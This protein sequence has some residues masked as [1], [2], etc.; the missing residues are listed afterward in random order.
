MA[1]LNRMS[2]AGELSEQVG[3]GRARRGQGSGACSP[4][5]AVPRRRCYG[6]VQPPCRR[7]TRVQVAP[8]VW[9]SKQQLDGAWAVVCVHQG[10]LHACR[11][12]ASARETSRDG[13][14]PAGERAK[15]CAALAWICGAPGLQLQP[16]H[17]P[18]ARHICPP[19]PPSPPMQPQLARGLRRWP[20]PSSHRSPAPP[21]MVV[22]VSSGR[23]TR[24]ARL[25]PS[26]WCTRRAVTSLQ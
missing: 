18:H 10:D 9:Q 6:L 11:V 4:P 22:G 16:A 21:W 26:R 12:G 25:T 1:G 5:P 7:R 13:S 19:H 23:G 2:P 8:A 14:A 15:V 24:N 3:S 20:G 17:R